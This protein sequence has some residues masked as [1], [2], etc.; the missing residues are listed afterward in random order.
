MF[1]LGGSLPATARI[2]FDTING[3]APDLTNYSS[4]RGRFVQWLDHPNS[5]F[6]GFTF[7]ITAAGT[8][9]YFDVNTSDDIRGETDDTS[10]VSIFI[11]TMLLVS[12]VTT[13][14]CKGN[15]IRLLT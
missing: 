11:G 2:T 14:S 13:N 5:A 15:G 12:T 1:K 10:F 6:N 7:T 9:P 3:V 4:R 8:A